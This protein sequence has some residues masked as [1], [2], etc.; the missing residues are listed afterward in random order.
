MSQKAFYFNA[1]DCVGCKT[2]VAACKDINHLQPGG[3]L[4]RKVYEYHSG[5]WNKVT[6]NGMTFDVPDISIYFVSNSCNHCAD[7]ICVTVC[8]YGANEKRADGV[9]YKDSSKCIGALCLQCVNSCPYHA[10]VLRPDTG[11]T[12][13]CNFCTETDYRVDSTHNVPAC[14]S[15]CLNRALDYGDLAA[16]QA[17]YGTNNAN[18]APL[19]SSHQTKPSVVII[20][21]K[22]NPDKGMGRVVNETEIGG[23]VVNRT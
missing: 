1:D 2:C 13:K 16:L 21:N 19:P 7:P 17:K 11:R 6:E 14:V 9:V 23:K 20:P 8:P 4:Y 15:A 10:P 18:I 22:T 5:G 3:G 12:G